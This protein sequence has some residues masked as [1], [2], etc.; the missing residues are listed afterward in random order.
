MSTNEKKMLEMRRD[1][2]FSKLCD[3]LIDR[4]KMLS[5]VHDN[6]AMMGEKYNSNQDSMMV[7]TRTH[8][9][10]ETSINVWSTKLDSCKKS[11]AFS[12]GER[13]E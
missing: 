10:V 6:I 9:M 2:S 12:P 5:Q 7:K 3:V 4:R 8:E 13:R 1:D 11:S